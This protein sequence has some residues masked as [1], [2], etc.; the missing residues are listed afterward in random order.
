MIAMQLLKKIQN[1]LDSLSPAEASVAALV[2]QDPSAFARSSVQVLAQQA[3]VSSPSVLRFCKRLGFAGLSDFKL[4]LAVSSQGTPFIHPRVGRL[5]D[6]KAMVQKIAQGSA[7]LLAAYA[8][9]CD[10]AALSA[11]TQSLVKTIK[12]GGRLDFLGFGNSAIVA[13]DAQHKFF[14][15]GAHTQALADAH[16]QV[17]AASLLGRD[18][19]VV[20]ISNS[21]T[22]QDLLHIAKLAKT[23]GA[24]SIA[25]SLSRSPLS[26]QVDHFL[27]ADHDEAFD[28]YSPMSSR[29]LQLL[30]IDILTT[31]VALAL[32]PGILPQLAQ[33]KRD[34]K[35]KK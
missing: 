13:L 17:M 34:L 8:Q 31:G 11:A 29:L 21:G 24:C 20:L 16:V 26:R 5:D 22:S 27:A 9:R 6:R 32:G 12:A 4:A 14:R 33:M 3:G 28:N 23:Q 25:I 35:G 10:T 1:Q 15:L 18:D 30:V 2:L 19:C 7:S